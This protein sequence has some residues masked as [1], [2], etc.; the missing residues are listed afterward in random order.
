MNGGEVCP[1]EGMEEKL[2]G[3]LKN[4]QFGSVR[5]PGRSRKFCLRKTKTKTKQQHVGQAGLEL[6]V[7]EVGPLLLIFLPSSFEC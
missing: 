7:A 2:T 3:L 1:V 6:Y 4:G 5:K